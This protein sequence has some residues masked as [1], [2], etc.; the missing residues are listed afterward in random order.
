VHP[1]C[2]DSPQ[3][4]LS[5]TPQAPWHGLTGVQHA[6]DAQTFPD[7]HELGHCTC[8]PHESVA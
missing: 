5:V 4:S 8:R 7:P 2:T 6:F 3:L 1:H